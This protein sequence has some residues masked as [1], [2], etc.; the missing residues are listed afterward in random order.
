MRQNKLNKNQNQINLIHNIANANRKNKF[1]R[2]NKIQN[3]TNQKNYNII[4]GIKSRSHSK[5]NNNRTER[6][7]SNKVRSKRKNSKKKNLDSFLR[8]FLNK[9]QKILKENYSEDIIN[10]NNTLLQANYSVD[11]DTYN[12]PVNLKKELISQH[13]LYK[14]N[15]KNS[16]CDVYEKSINKKSFKE[17]DKKLLYNDNY[18]IKN[19]K[20]NSTNLVSNNS[21]LNNY[22]NY[23]NIC[24]TNNT[25]NK[26]GKIKKIEI[27]HMKK[28][29]L[30]LSQKS[31]D[32]AKT[33]TNKTIHLTEIKKEKN[34]STSNYFNIIRKKRNLLFKQR[35][36]YSKSFSIKS[37]K[38]GYVKNR[39][40]NSLKYLNHKI[41]KLSSLSEVRKNRS[42]TKEKKQ[43]IEK[44]EKSLFDTY[45]MIEKLKTEENLKNVVKIKSFVFYKNKNYLTENCIENKKHENK[46]DKSNEKKEIAID[47][48]Y[49]AFINKKKVDNRKDNKKAKSKLN[50][51]RELRKLETIEQA[52]ES[53][54]K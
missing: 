32:L 33:K 6:K 47:I 15:A 40:E 44:I 26:L 18:C 4:K 25:N 52:L 16:K 9:E 36:V 2:P 23:D 24:K 28:N 12:D 21:F 19:D 14:K 3:I 37:R 5:H 1:K 50:I 38:K 22:S 29:K 11:F 8:K 34:N 27:F 45:K 39:H 49:N 7:E 51:K 43:A 31:L 54:K 10:Q 17:K 42:N 41:M 53:N 35:L 48:K 20:R 13:N 46:V 30:M